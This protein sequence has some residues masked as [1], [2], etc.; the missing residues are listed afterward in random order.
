MKV[1]ELSQSEK[2]NFKK[3]LLK[4]EVFLK[5]NLTHLAQTS[6]SLYKRTLA[7]ISVINKII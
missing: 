5:H 7:Y 2:V 3:E 1:K 6:L 4:Y